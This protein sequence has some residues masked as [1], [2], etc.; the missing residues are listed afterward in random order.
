MHGGEH[1]SKIIIRQKYYI[2]LV[3]ALFY[4]FGTCRGQAGELSPPAEGSDINSA[5]TLSIGLAE[6]FYRKDFIQKA[7]LNGAKNTVTIDNDFREV[8]ALWLVGNYVFQSKCDNSTFRL[9]PADHETGTFCKNTIREGLFTGIKIISASDTS[10]A[11]NS[12]PNGFAIG[13]EF[14]FLTKAGEDTHNKPVY[15]PAWTFGVG[16]AYMESQRLADGIVANKPLPAPYS[17]IRFRDSYGTGW[18]IMITRRVW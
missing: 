18:V 10:T 9:S 14:V 17:G 8:P 12:V 3:F 4:L 6:G 5:F 15:D 13:P 16:F 11:N 7:S 1:V 2:Q